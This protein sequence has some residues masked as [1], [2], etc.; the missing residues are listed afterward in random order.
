MSRVHM[1]VERG[2]TSEGLREIARR[3]ASALLASELGR[4]Q[5]EWRGALT[6]VTNTLA[7]LV[8][9]CERTVSAADDDPD[10]RRVATGREARD[11]RC[12]GRSD[13]NATH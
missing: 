3:E 12:C 4:Q 10:G 6:S 1:A 13:L 9:A 11:S 5:E 2:S 8:S 7:G